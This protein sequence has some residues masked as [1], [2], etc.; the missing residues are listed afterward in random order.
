MNEERFEQ[1]GV[2]DA[3]K[4]QG[5]FRRD[6]LK[7]GGGCAINGCVCQ[8]AVVLDAVRG[9]WSPC[10]VYRI[11]EHGTLH[12]SGLKRALPGISKKVL[13]EHL[14]RLEHAGILKREPRPAARPEVLYSL[15]SRGGE[16]KA[17]LDSLQDVGARWE[18]EGVN[19][20]GAQAASATTSARPR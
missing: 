17:V 4:G 1:L 15:T 5:R 18:C 7:M 20:D 2:I 13:T 19:K 10:I 16:L 6:L 3:R 9:R 14:R 8:A 11:G 12:F